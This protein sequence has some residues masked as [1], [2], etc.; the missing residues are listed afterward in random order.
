MAGDS[1][2]LAPGQSS[3]NVLE[4]LSGLARSVLSSALPGTLRR[5]KQDPYKSARAGHDGRAAD[6]RIRPFAG[7]GDRWLVS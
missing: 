4:M 3:L 1:R 5:E 6:L 7:D 2:R